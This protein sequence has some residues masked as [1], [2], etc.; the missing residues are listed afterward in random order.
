MTQLGVDQ[1]KNKEKTATVTHLMCRE[2]QAPIVSALIKGFAKEFGTEKTHALA[3]EIIC[4]DAVS[5]G[6]TLA[7][8]YSGNTLNEL[9]KVVKEVWSKDGTM[10]IENISLNQTCLQFNVTRCGYAEMYERMGIKELGVLLSC[11]RDFS[12]MEGFNPQ[13]ELIRTKTIM[14]GDNICDFCYQTK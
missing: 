4:Q 12:F 1:M 3:K 7:E 14:E 11:G 9:L 6:K 10:E 8:K 2:I 13:I 5:A